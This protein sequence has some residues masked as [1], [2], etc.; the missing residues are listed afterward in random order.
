VR[1]TRSRELVAEGHSPSV[2]ARVARISRRAIYRIPKTKPPSPQRSGPPADEVDRAIVDVA[3]A[4]Q[5]D[6]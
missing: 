5:T 3:E 4:N 2:V 6:G 1:V